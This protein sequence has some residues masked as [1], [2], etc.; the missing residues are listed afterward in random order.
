MEELKWQSLCDT[1]QPC[2]TTHRLPSEALRVWKSYGM[3][4]DS[5]KTWLHAIR[6]LLSFA[7]PHRSPRTGPAANTTFM[8]TAADIFQVYKEEVF[9]VL[10]GLADVESDPLKPTS[11]HTNVTEFYGAVA[12]M[13]RVYTKLERFSEADALWQEVGRGATPTA[14][15]AYLARLAGEPTRA[16][17]LLMSI[18]ELD[19]TEYDYRTVITAYAQQGNI[20]E[21]E[22]VFSMVP[23]VTLT[24]DKQIRVGTTTIL[25]HGYNEQAKLMSDLTPAEQTDMF[26]KGAESVEKRLEELQFTE[27]PSCKYL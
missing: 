24:Q 6:A 10:T 5:P 2:P 9:D 18:P 23:P 19:R 16:R 25:L 26:L 17:E 27:E 3:E 20:F 1:I 7:T 15:R 21:A 14:K 4:V 13:I 8:N 11:E 22:K 12:M